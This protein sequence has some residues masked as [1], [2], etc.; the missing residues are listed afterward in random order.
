MNIWVMCISEPLP[1]DKGTQRHMRAGMLTRMLLSMGHEVTWWTS[2]FN[3]SSKRHRANQSQET[4]SPEGVRLMLLH[5]IGYS[6]NVG[7]PRL[8]NHFQLAREFTRIAA[9]QH[10]PDLIFCCWPA[11]ELGFAAVCYAER[12]SI[13]ILLDVRDLWPDIF[14]DAVPRPARPLAK[15]ALT[16]YARVTRSAFRRATGIVGISQGYLDWGLAQAGRRRNANDALFPL[17]YQEPDWSKASVVEGKKSLQALGVD[18]SRQVC[19]FLGSFGSTYDLEPVILAARQLET[20]GMMSPQFVLSGEGEG[21]ERYERLAAGLHNVVFTGWLDADRIAAMM[22]MAH[23][24][25]AAY[26]KGAPQ[27]LPN[28]IFEY[29]AAGLPILSSLDGECKQFLDDN[30]CGI[31]YMAGSAEAL[32]D[33][34]T[35][36]TEN[37]ALARELGTNA[38]RAYRERYSAAIV[39]TQLVEHMAELAGQP[40]RALTAMA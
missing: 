24:A 40:A 37:K 12:Q 27:G 17:G 2:A 30:A 26:R 39:Y 3:H 15:L 18:A 31:S 20:R 1:I 16:P 32:L 8:I 19:W 7:V 22:R 6:R 35:R 4:M 14:L 9:A 5:G 21:R 23:V 10:P 34:F 38:R 36:L 25:I 13:P 28:K 11:V 29:M 33:A